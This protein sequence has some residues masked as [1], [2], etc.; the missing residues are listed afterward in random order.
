MLIQARFKEVQ[1]S[2]KATNEVKAASDQGLGD[3]PIIET[4]IFFNNGESFNSAELKVKALSELKK[5]GIIPG[6][7]AKVIINMMCKPNPECYVLFIEGFEKPLSHITFDQAGNVTEF[8]SGVGKEGVV[9][10]NSPLPD[11][12]EGSVAKEF[13]N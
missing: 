5:R 13:Q 3:A 1:G 8:F 10:P 7:K 11:I 6:I 2:A 12:P 4:S 9:A